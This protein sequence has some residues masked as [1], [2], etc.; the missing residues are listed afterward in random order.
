MLRSKNL[1]FCKNYKLIMGCV[2][3]SMIHTLLGLSSHHPWAY[4][5]GSWTL[6][7]LEKSMSQEHI[8]LSN[9]LWWENVEVSP[10]ALWLITGSILPLQA[11]MMIMCKLSLTTSCHVHSGMPQICHTFTMR[12]WGIR[13]SLISLPLA[14]IGSDKVWQSFSLGTLVL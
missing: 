4:P 6:L 2:L 3:S 10:S 8:S 11:F 1:A 9:K 12:G 13:N 14:S 7:L 5:S